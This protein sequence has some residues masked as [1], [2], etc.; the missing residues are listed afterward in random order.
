MEG[1]LCFCYKQD[2]WQMDAY[3]FELLNCKHCLPFSFE[4]HVG[5]VSFIKGHKK[6]VLNRSRSSPHHSS[7]MLVTSPG[8]YLGIYFKALKRDPRSSGHKICR[9]RIIRGIWLKRCSNI[10]WLCSKTQP[11]ILFCL[12]IGQEAG[13]AVPAYQRAKDSY[14]GSNSHQLI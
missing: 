4:S 2:K 7:A 11:V 3:K 9:C 1:V 6:H 10:C 14:S 8:T 12:S 5:N 13:H